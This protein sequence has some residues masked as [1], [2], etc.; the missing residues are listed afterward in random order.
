[1][2]LTH[3][4][5][6]GC[7]DYNPETGSLTWK[8]RPVAHFKN[9]NVF[10][11]WNTR[12][13]N[14]TAGSLIKA[15]GYIEISLNK[16]HYL[17]HRLCYFHYHGYMP[18]NQIDHKDRIRT[19]NRILNLR[20]ATQQCQN[21]N[22]GML[23]NNTSGVKGVSFYRERKKWIAQI[24]IGQKNMPLGYYKLFDEAVK[25][26]WEAEK[27]YNFPNCN[28]SSSSYNYLKDKGLIP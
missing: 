27:K 11:S 19:N 16:K 28:T 18:E 1:M 22:A 7:L 4:Y 2:K 14:K 10:G 23:S 15:T 12:W 24:V 20:E 9:K 6:L 5:L 25:A 17:A 13:A 21:R 8:E 26:R 3:I